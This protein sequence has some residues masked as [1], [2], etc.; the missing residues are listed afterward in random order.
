M[1]VVSLQ[2]SA[3]ERVGERASTVALGRGVFVADASLYIARLSTQV[4]PR[5]RLVKS[6]SAHR[7]AVT[8]GADAVTYLGEEVWIMVPDA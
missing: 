5:M 8:Y 6:A 7:E 2:L 1:A 4:M 3:V